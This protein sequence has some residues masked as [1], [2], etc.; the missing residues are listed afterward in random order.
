MKS[1]AYLK[2]FLRQL[3]RVSPNSEKVLNNDRINWIVHFYVLL[4][5]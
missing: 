1:T 3:F 4:Q 2:V 5:D